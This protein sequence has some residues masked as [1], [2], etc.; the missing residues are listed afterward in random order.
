MLGYLS[1]STFIWKLMYDIIMWIII[2]SIVFYCIQ[3]NPTDYDTNYRK[4]YRTIL[5]GVCVLVAIG[6]LFI[7][8]ENVLL[9]NY[10]LST[11][12]TFTPNE[13]MIQFGMGPNVPMREAS[14]EAVFALPTFEQWL[15][16][17]KINCF[18]VWTAFGIMFLFFKK[19]STRPIAKV[20]K[21]FGYLFLLFLV[22]AT[23]D[24]HHF[25]DLEEFIFT[26]IALLIVWLLLRTYR[27][28]AIAP[29]L[30][31]ESKQHCENEDFIAI[32][33]EEQ[34]ITDD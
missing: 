5:G 17:S 23:L 29:T 32:K 15:I 31:E 4:R 13:T 25:F 3:R 34:I 33:P 1:E 2:L 7:N 22:P 12:G 28:D 9:S 21:A 6:T 14:V 16:F 8:Y 30:P 18:C 26:G 27:K 19:S 24:S 11:F 10:Y 20:R